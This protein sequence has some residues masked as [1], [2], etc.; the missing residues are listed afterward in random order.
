M[1]LVQRAWESVLRQE[2]GQE[3]LD[4]LRKLNAMCSP[5]GQAPEYP[6]A[7]VLDIIEH[8]DFKAA[9]QSARAFAL[10][11]QL[12]N[13]VEQHYEQ[14]ERRNEHQAIAAE[15][16]DAQRQT[17]DKQK[18][19]DVLFPALAARSVEPESLQKL[20]EVLDI[21]LVFTAHPTEIVRHTIRE[22]Q[23]TISTLLGEL[24]RLNDSTG[25]ENAVLEERLVE[26][27]MLWW[28]T[29]ELHQFKPAV[30]DEVDFTLHYFET[31]VFDAVPRLS[32]R[33]AANLKLAFPHIETPAPN[34]CSF[35]SWV[36]SDRDGNPS[37]TPDVT[38]QT[39]RYQR[40]LVLSK[41]IS[42]VKSLIRTLSVSLHWSDVNSSLLDD[43]EQDRQQFPEVYES[44]A[45]R[46]RQE[47]YRL[48]LSFMLKKLEVT[49]DRN[50][51]LQRPEFLQREQLIEGGY[52]S[53]AEF[54]AELRAIQSSLNFSD[55]PCHHLDRLIAQVE[56]FG[57]HLAHLD[58]RQDSR[59]HEA[60]LTDICNYLRILPR[61]YEDLSEF[62][63][64]DFLVG[65]LRNRRPLI[66]ADPDL[67][68]RTLE[69]IETFRT[70]R[71]IQQ[72]FGSQ[73]C[74]TYIIS[75][76]RCASDL[77]EVLLFAK[78]AGLYDPVTA[79]GALAVIPLFETVDDLKRAPD[80]M[81][82]LFELTFYRTYLS[83]QGDLQE[84][85]LGY[86]DSN[87]DSGFLSSNWEIYKAQQS[88]QQVAESNGLALRIFHGRGGSVGRGGG[89]AYEA[90]LAQPGASIA[91]RI[92]I[93]EQGEV[94]ASKYSLMEAAVYNLETV[95]CAV[96]QSSLRRSHLSGSHD[97]YK[98]MESLA[99]A[100]RSAYKELV[101]Q[102]P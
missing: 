59:V 15:T 94:L 19:F 25:W 39:A 68:D 61:P 91:G 48:K 57:F 12:I 52:N 36:G 77:L 98:L 72:E 33:L 45:L 93:T 7:E 40:N 54:L 87:K 28:R 3:L 75:M 53:A 27:L 67:S 66:P 23:R 71:Y 34:F 102:E 43:L 10:F 60:A 35:G 63:K 16:I 84:V 76:S 58:V 78:E 38:W 42:A 46:Y 65:E 69:I 90:I 8:L 49:R 62:E 83:H 88:L 96:I 9:I 100:S 51:Q 32:E 13:I 30:L 92:K 47:P 97:W 99:A 50:Q 89:P 85:M 41:Y 1:R 31:V 26:E 20:L 5:E 82:S 55:L 81:R 44:L 17:P 6:A 22:K 4:L 21:R 86:S 95:T 70:L 14:A 64:V 79:T 37:V 80:V 18:Q 2:C 24:D 73:T 29:D 74:N 11:F 56:V 101:Y